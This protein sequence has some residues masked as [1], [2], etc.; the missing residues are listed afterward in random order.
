MSRTRTDTDDVDP[1]EIRISD[2][3]QASGCVLY[4]GRDA[5][6]WLTPEAEAVLCEMLVARRKVL[7]FRPPTPTPL[8]PVPAD[9]RDLMEVVSGSV[10]S[11]PIGPDAA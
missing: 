3:T 6:I 1:R 8:H 5:L 2:R 10:F 11:G 4:F 9:V 7:R